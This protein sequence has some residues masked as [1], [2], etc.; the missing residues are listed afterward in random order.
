MGLATPPP[1]RVDPLTTA[2]YFWSI[3]D[4]RVQDTVASMM[5]SWGRPRQRTLT[6]NFPIAGTDPPAAGWVASVGIAHPIRIVGWMV[7]AI[8][9]GSITV[10][11]RVSSVLANSGTQPAYTSL[12]GASHLITHSGYTSSSMDTSAWTNTQV[13]G[14]SFLNVYVIG[15]AGIADAT[16]ALRVIDMES[17]TLAP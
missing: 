14:G 7:N 17:R 2:N 12:P 8:T 10:D 3:L 4:K 13:D 16:L 15:S 9:A 5:G 1:P 11:L 6:I